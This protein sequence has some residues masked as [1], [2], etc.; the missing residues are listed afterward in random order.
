[1]KIIFG[2]KEKELKKMKDAW[3]INKALITAPAIDKDK[4]INLMKD[5][6][7]KIYTLLEID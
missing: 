4:L 5:D 6:L 2:Y 1:M 3:D 7:N